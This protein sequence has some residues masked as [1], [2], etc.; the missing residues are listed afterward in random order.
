MN[1][2]PADRQSSPQSIQKLQDLD[3]P[4][5]GTFVEVSQSKMGSR[6]YHIRRDRDLVRIFGFKDLDEQ[7]GSVKPETLVRI[8]YLGRDR[9]T[10]V[11]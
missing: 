3:A 4:L 11:T 7:M 8:T 1:Y 6:V 10:R 5:E 2:K 9:H